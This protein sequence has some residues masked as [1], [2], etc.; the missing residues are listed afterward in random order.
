MSMY[1]SFTIKNKAGNLV[2]KL[3]AIGAL[4]PTDK[5]SIFNLI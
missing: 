2:T 5:E 3:K 1:T 4:K